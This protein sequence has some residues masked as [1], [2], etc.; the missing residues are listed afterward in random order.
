MEWVLF[1]AI[2]IFLFF[3]VKN[4][5]P[6]SEKKELNN[7]NITKD[8]VLMKIIGTIKTML[9]TNF[10]TIEEILDG[11]MVIE[12]GSVGWVENGG[13]NYDTKK[14]DILLDMKEMSTNDRNF[15]AE[16][17]ANYTNESYI[18]RDSYLDTFT[19]IIHHN[20]ME[21]SI[22]YKNLDHLNS[23]LRNEFE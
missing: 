12:F 15:A 14:Y 5:M 18:Y 9:H 21:N 16:L 6:N 7:K 1:I 22:F 20:L 8:E 23:Y 17:L 4:N 11:K 2:L 3:V 19:G 10:A 13:D